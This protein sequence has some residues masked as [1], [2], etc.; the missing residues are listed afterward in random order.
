MEEKFISIVDSLWH[1]S[2]KARDLLAKNG[3]YVL[4]MRS[5]DTG[6]GNSLETFVV[7]NYEGSVVVNFEI[8]DW[9]YEKEN[10]KEIFDMHKWLKKHP[11]VEDRYFDS[12]VQKR[13]EA[14]LRASGMEEREWNKAA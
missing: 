8:I 6:N 10:D 3:L 13:V 7:V 2:R 9:D 5:W 14:I 12:E 11:E 4:D 1:P